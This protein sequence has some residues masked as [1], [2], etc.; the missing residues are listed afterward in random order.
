VRPGFVPEMTPLGPQLSALAQ[1]LNTAKRHSPAWLR[2]LAVVLERVQQT[3][4]TRPDRYAR[5]EATGLRGVDRPVPF[6]ASVDDA[7]AL[8]DGVRERLRSQVGPAADW[9]RVHNDEPAHRLAREYDADAVSVGNDVYFARGRYQPHDSLGFGLLA[10][11]AVHVEHAMR[12]DAPWRSTGASALAAEEASAFAVERAARRGIPADARHRLVPPPAT[13]T[14]VPPVAPAMSTS[15]VQRPVAAASDRGIDALPSSSP[16]D[17]EA[18]RQTLMRDLMSQ[19]RAD[20]ER[21]G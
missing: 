7:L 15:A 3:S 18:L 12:P 10:H 6:E 20:M 1:A 21:G 17:M 13:G 16:L 4:L 11:E 19:I 14:K 2:P 5:V 8:P 9:V